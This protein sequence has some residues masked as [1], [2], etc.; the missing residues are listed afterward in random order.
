MSIRRRILVVEPSLDQWNR[1]LG[2]LTGAGHDLVRVSDFPSAKPELDERPPDLLITEL[3]LGAFNGLHLAIRAR[4]SGAGT[5]SIVL[6]E[7]DAVLQAEA[8]REGV[9]YIT[10]P[11]DE[12]AFVEAVRESLGDYRPARRSPR[13]RVPRADA[14][15]GDVPASLL[16]IS[17][18]G[19][20]LE[21]P[22]EE[23]DRLAPHFV[24]RVPKFD[25]SC[26]MRCVWVTRAPKPGVV[27]CGA[28]LDTAD[29]AS[30]LAWRG[31]V[32]EMP[33]WTLIQ[34]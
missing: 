20:K 16:D 27:W 5:R 6:G 3:K 4:M 18:E 11:L 26:R 1:L 22:A 17:Y 28:S 24:V 14:L 23:T 31:L 21:L 13:K 32:D 15:V 2:W 30:S 34:N 33:G 7:P 12:R 19:L 25:V 9:R 10:H 29:L 8:Q